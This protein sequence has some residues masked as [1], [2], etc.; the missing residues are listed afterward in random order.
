MFTRTGKS[1]RFTKHGET[2]TQQRGISKKMANLIF[3]Y[4]DREARR[5]GGMVGLSLS[6]AGIRELRSDGVI[7]SGDAESL[8]KIVLLYAYFSEQVVTVIK[9]RSRR[10]KAYRRDSRRKYAHHKRSANNVGA[11]MSSQSF[12]VRGGGV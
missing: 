9:G 7:S 11:G 4:A 8:G 10:A 5:G 6:R 2:R 3:T 1:L 12:K